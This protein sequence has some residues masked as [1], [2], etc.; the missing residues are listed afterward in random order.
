MKIVVAL[1]SLS[2]VIMVGLI[3]QAVH[4]E[5]KMRKAKTRIME[6][7]MEV[8]RKEESIVEVKTKL[9]TL[10]ASLKTV[11]TKVEELKQKK[12]EASKSTNDFGQSLATCNNE[13]ARQTH[14][15][16]VH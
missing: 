4:Q 10:K 12:E 1:V 8:K 7:S 13:K 6:N 2:V 9:E 14:Y 5:I 11:N 16:F 3:F 15:N